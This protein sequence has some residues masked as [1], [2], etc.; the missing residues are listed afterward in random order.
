MNKSETIV[1]LAKALSSFQGEV[2]D[3]HKDKKGFNY[4]YADL[5]SILEIARPLLLKNGLSVTQL[6]ESH[7]INDDFHVGVESVL[8]HNSGEWV[9]SVFT[10]PLQASK[11]MSLAQSAGS[12]ITYARRY[13]LAAILGITQTDNDAVIESPKAAVASYVKPQEVKMPSR[14]MFN[15]FQRLLTVKGV[16]DKEMDSWVAHAQVKALRD[17]NI[18]Q[19]AKLI[20]KLSNREDVTNE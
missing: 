3:A 15:E 19:V 1:E 11:N 6:C 2:Q 12:V 14:V 16:A 5:S 13:S 9:S 17:L 10:M 4:K 8:M 20:T 18:D 7:L